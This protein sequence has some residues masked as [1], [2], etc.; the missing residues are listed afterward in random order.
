MENSTDSSTENSSASESSVEESS[1]NEDSSSEEL[2]ASKW[3]EWEAVSQPTCTENGEKIR[4]N[5]DDPTEVETAPIAAR[6]HNYSQ[7]NGTCAVCGDEAEIPALDAEQAFPLVEPCAHKVEEIE[8]GLCSCTQGRGEEYNRL[9]LTE[10]CYTIETVK[11]LALNNEIWLSFSV[12]EAGQYMLYSVENNNQAT[13]T[14]HDASMAF[15]SPVGESARVDENG[16][17]YSYI[18][19]AEKYFNQEW[20]ATFRIQAK[21]GTLVKICFVKIADPVW[22]PKSVYTYVY[23]TQI[24]GQKAPNGGAGYKKTEVPYNSEYYYSDPA[25]GGD[26]Y[27][28]LATGEI[29]FAAI[30]SAPERLL[31]NGMFSV[32]HYEGSALNLPNGYTADG[33]YNVLNYVPF[34]MNSMYDDDIFATDE[35]GNYLVNLEKN[36]YQNYCNAD[37]LYPVNA[38]LFNFLNLY[39]QKNQPIDEAV[40]YDDWKNQEDWLWLSACYF[41]APLN[42]GIESNPLPL[43]VGEY[44]IALPE[45]D[46]YYC[47]IEEAGT[48]K[49]TCSDSEV[50][51][52]E[53]YETGTVTVVVTADSPLVFTFASMDAKTVTVTVEK[54]DD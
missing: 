51:I 30:N 7:E 11:N 26:G 15:V 20:R 47:K 27:Y 54:I 53:N 45:A 42:Q 36:C 41:Y 35:N 3:S 18:S 9:E 39:V 46:F 40:S 1:S 5:L 4:Y 17:F 24:N 13:A 37:G 12:K 50:L 48:Y 10:G 43:T 22:E 2:P 6:G 21:A 8:N 23:P 31:S 52:G 34:I 19:C 33:D 38:E 49:I 14:R 29:I 16:D 44:E 32:I 25:T 28:H